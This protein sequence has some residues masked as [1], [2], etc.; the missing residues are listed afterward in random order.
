MSSKTYKKFFKIAIVQP[1][2]KPFQILS[3]QIQ[4]TTATNMG[5][6]L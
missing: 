3:F 5:K 1:H 6:D 2:F 4:N